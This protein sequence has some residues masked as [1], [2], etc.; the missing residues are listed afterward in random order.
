MMLF[1]FYFYAN[2][3]KPLIK[4][5]WRHDNHHVLL[6]APSIA[7]DFS[8]ARCKINSIKKAKPFFNI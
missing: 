5:C 1:E 4:A 3:I 7:R 6:H 2:T 8:Q